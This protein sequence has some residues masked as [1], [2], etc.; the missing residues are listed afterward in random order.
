ASQKALGRDQDSGLLI[1][2]VEDNSPASRGGLIIGDIIVGIA[3]QPISDHDGLLSRLSGE[4]VGSPT[5]IEIL[6]GGQRTQ[7]D[8]TVGERK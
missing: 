2:G 4:T 3:D 5:P 1:V 6:R 7:V 8:V